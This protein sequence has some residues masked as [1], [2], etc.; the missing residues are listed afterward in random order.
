MEWLFKSSGPLTVGAGQVGGFART[1]FAQGD[2][3]DMQF[4]VMPLSVD[5][6]G[7][8][9]HDYPGFTASACQCRPLSKG[10]VQIRSAD[11]FAAPRIQTNYLSEELDRKVLAAGVQ[12]L[13]DIYAQPAF[14]DLI[15]EEILPGAQRKT[16][17]DLLEFARSAGGT[18]FH[19]VG[20]CRMGSDERAVVDP[21]LKVRGVQGLRV[22]DASI[23][24]NMVSANTNAASIMI[25]EKGADLVLNP[26]ERAARAAD[27]RLEPVHHE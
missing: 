5:K 17:E 13:R 18:V 15:A 16:R 1:E 9:L 2:R 3:A 19:P 10:R 20:T 14:R 25:G 21:E 23:M 8:P 22:I 12:M 11:P 27:N 7:T 24:P 6:P 26:A 4:N